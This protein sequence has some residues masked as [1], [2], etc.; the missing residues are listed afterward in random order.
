V[1]SRRRGRGGA[2]VA[3]RAGRGR[4]AR[5]TLTACG[6]GGDPVTVGLITKQEENPFWVTMREVAE[7]TAGDETVEL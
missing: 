3:S 5:L 2:P 1:S 6:D 4:A 7:D